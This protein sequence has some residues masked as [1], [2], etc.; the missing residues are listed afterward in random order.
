MVADQLRARIL[1]GELPDGATLPKQEDLFEE[2]GV[3]L[4]AIREAL[5]ILETEGLVTVLRGNVG[6]AVVRQPR[7]SKVAY[8]VG[9][10]L[11]SRDV[12]IEDV[13]SAL[14]RLEAVCV[15]LAAERA[16][17]HET[18]V[19]RLRA[20]I[21]ESRAVVDD[22][23]AYVQQARGFHED[24]VATCGNETMILVVGALE[25]LWSAHVDTLTRRTAQFGPFLDLETRRHSIDEHVR[26]VD[27]IESGDTAGAEEI[28]LAHLAEPERYPF[29]AE[30]TTV[31]AALIGDA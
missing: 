22:A 9:L 5:R 15:A 16:D 14:R 25:S 10:V 11:E 24:V 30:G 4:P 18:V 6:G 17:R 2:F 7:P 26:L 12:G 27:A 21:A 23:D 20:R 8:M 1:A 31:R 19:P 29:V 3:G 13:A 28:V